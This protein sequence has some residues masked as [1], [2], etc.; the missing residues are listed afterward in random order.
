MKDRV[1][2]ASEFKA[3]CLACLDEIEH[4]GGPITITR[5]GKPV[6]VLG[7]AIRTIQKSPRNSWARK[8]RIVGDIVS[9]DTSSSWE[10]ARSK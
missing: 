2:S 9:Q 3:K 5:R 7:P 4:H 8:G 10:V 6:A 1:L